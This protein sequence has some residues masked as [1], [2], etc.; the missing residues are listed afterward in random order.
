MKKNYIYSISGALF[1]LLATAC[2]LEGEQECLPCNKI[3]LVDVQL[4][5]TL[6]AAELE[7]PL[8]LFKR[9]AGTQEPYTFDRSY[10]S[11]SDGM[12]LKLPFAEM[13]DYDYRFLAVAQP[14]GSEW[15]SL[16]SAAGL[17][18]VQGV[19]WDDLRMACASGNASV[20]G[21][22]GFTDMDGEAILLAG[23]VRLTL[24]RVAG[25]MLFD[26][27]RIGSSLSEPEGIVSADVESVIDRVTKI[28][29]AYENSTT[30]LRFDT[31]NRLI[32]ATY[33]SQPFRQVITPDAADFKVSLPQVDKGLG[34]YDAELRGSLRIAGAALLPSDAKM[35]VKM[36]FTYYDTTPACGNTHAGDHTVACYAQREV[37]LNLPA[38]SSATG[39]P[40]SS[41]CYTVNRAGL[42]TD[43]II[44]IPAGGGIETDFE[45]L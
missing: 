29:I 27:Y 3:R 43:R 33:A 39:L 41:D 23:S 6:P 20:E 25:Q 17:P 15:L 35:R 24:T 19:S 32:P 14:L 44:D 38:A 18:L 10:D 37:T 8:Y 12:T 9:P 11:A 30:S 31:D 36:V 28:E 13:K 34:L 21:Y 26:F 22:S 45:W 4:A 42:R 2:G 16:R 40:V 1:L 5:G 7:T